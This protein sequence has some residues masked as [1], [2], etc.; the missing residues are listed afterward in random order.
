[1]K[2]QLRERS[3]LIPDIKK[4]DP[5][6]WL[7]PRVYVLSCSYWESHVR[8][9]RLVSR[10]MKLIAQHFLQLCAWVSEW[11]SEWPPVLFYWCR[12]EVLLGMTGFRLGLRQTCIFLLFCYLREILNVELKHIRCLDRLRAWHTHMGLL[13]IRSLIIYRVIHKSLRNFRTRLRNNQ[14]IHGRKEH[15]NR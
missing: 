6:S 4:M 12:R 5:Y 14:D 15:I 13:C 7:E 3:A 1:M 9:V 11:M 2:L 10:C 8:F